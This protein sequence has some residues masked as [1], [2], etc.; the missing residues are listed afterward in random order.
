M[1]KRNRLFSRP[2]IR[3][4]DLDSRIQIEARVTDQ[5][6][7]DLPSESFT[8]MDTRLDHYAD[9]F[10]WRRYLFNHLG[11]FDGKE[12]LEIGCGL[13]MTPVMFALAGAT[14][15]AIDVAP[16]TV[17]KV[18][19]FAASKGVAGRVIGHV[20]PA[21]RL[22]FA[23]GEF[24]IVYGKA[25][26]HH[27]RLDLAIPEISRVMKPGGKGGFQDPLGHNV[28]LELARDYLAYRG[29]NTLKGTDLPFQMEDVRAVG[30]AFSS[31]SFRGFELS[32]MA[33]RALA[34]RRNSILRRGLEGFDEFL[35]AHIPHLERYGRLVV[36]CVTK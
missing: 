32:S 4:L 2:E 35:F 25:A 12:V 3:E 33:A 13:T 22:P 16:Q 17:A 6:Y 30:R 11:S 19:E 21:E 20:C 27:M 23:D 28:L 9:E 15:H 31:Y 29:K 5:L 10:P 24:D 36:I 1:F 8:D 7:A 26:L 34:L 14:V 18:V